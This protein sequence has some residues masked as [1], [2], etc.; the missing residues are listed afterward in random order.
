LKQRSL[1]GEREEKSPRLKK[2]GVLI[3]L[4]SRHCGMPVAAPGTPND[5]TYKS[6][7]YVRIGVRQSEAHRSGLRLPYF[8]SRAIRA[9]TGIG[10]AYT[11]ISHVDTSAM[12]TARKHM[13]PISGLSASMNITARVASSVM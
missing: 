9:F 4:P 10:C 6:G 8:T 7:T 5:N 2:G 11:V 12:P 3:G 1:P 13:S